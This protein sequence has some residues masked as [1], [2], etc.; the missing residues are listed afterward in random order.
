M[1]YYEE[2][3]AQRHNALRGTVNGLLIVFVL[4]LVFSAG[5]YSGVHLNGKLNPSK[6]TKQK[7]IGYTVISRDSVEWCDGKRVK[8]NW[9]VFSDYKKRGKK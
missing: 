9:H 1:D 7:C 8:Y 5:W 4:A 6:I 2:K 3:N